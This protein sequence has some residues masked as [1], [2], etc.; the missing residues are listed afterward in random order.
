MGYDK[1]PEL[2]NCSTL[3]KPTEHCSVLF[4]TQDILQIRGFNLY[5]ETFS[6]Q[7]FARNQKGRLETLS[8][9][10]RQSTHFIFI[11]SIQH[12][13]F[14]FSF[15]LNLTVC[16]PSL[17]ISWSS[18]FSGQTGQKKFSIEMSF[19]VKKATSM[20]LK[21]LELAVCE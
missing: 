8:E 2:N 21:G 6:D 12:Q 9:L 18:T 16:F 5:L 3:K 13:A 11:Y 4:S 20:K 7:M 15:G 17:S 19:S 14:Q 1:K 10:G